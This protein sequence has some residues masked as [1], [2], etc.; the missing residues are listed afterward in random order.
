MKKFLTAL[1]AILLTTSIAA[2]AAES[3]IQNWVNDLISPITTKE[4]E[5]RYVE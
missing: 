3:R 2:N 5:L 4:K 1:L